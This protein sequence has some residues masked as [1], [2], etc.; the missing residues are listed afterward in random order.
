MKLI[1]PTILIIIAI[2]L[3]FTVANPMLKDIK[4]LRTD[5]NTY[6]TA[7]NS[8]TNLQD[9]ENSLIETY[10]GITQGDKDKLNKFLPNTVNNIKFILEVEQIANL[11]SMPIKNIKF[12]PKDVGENSTSTT[13]DANNPDGVIVIPTDQASMLPYGVFPIEFTTE[14]SYD[15][16]VL[17]LQDLEHNLRLVDVKSVSFKIPDQNIPVNPTDKVTKIVDP[18]IYE[19]TLKV[20]TYWLK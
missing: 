19:F 2:I 13:P 12:D 14:G 16:F 4:I 3:F 1:F 8:S 20:E 7:L 6:N 17:F 9:I 10:K 15:S 11:H 18:N 5:V